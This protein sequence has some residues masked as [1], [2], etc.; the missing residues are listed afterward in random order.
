MKINYSDNYFEKDSVEIWDEWCYRERF[1]IKPL[2]N[3]VNPN[4]KKINISTSNVNPNKKLNSSVEFVGH[5]K[6]RGDIYI[7]T[8][9]PLNIIGTLK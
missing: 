3:W 8:T 9:T 1:C 5:L 6:P 7:V 4:F 2:T